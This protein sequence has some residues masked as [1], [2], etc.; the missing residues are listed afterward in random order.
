MLQINKCLPQFITFLGC[1]V[2]QCS[3]FATCKS[4]RSKCR[5]Q[6]DE[7]C[8]VSVQHKEYAGSIQMLDFIIRPER[9]YKS[10]K[11]RLRLYTLRP[12]FVVRRLAE[13]LPPLFKKLQ[14]ERILAPFEC[15]VDCPHGC[16]STHVLR[17]EVL[18]KILRHQRSAGRKREE[19]LKKTF[20]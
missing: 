16:L 12:L 7:Q 15:S 18:H 11:L 3:Y 20:S 4:C 14:N 5:D 1:D 17:A 6:L 10:A 19:E 9:L 13:E 2:A 8:V